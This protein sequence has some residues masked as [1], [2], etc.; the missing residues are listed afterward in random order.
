MVR[1]ICGQNIKEPQVFNPQMM[2]PGTSLGN[3]LLMVFL[4]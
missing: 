1:E 4:K 2:G 3:H